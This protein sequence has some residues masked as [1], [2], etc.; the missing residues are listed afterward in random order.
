MDINKKLVEYNSQLHC[1]RLQITG[2]RIFFRAIFPPKPGETEP[3]RTRITSHCNASASGL[4]L[5]YERAKLIDAE[6]V[7]GTF[8]WTP[9][10]RGKLKSYAQVEIVV[11]IVLVRDWVEKFEE[12]YWL[13]NEKTLNKSESFRQNYGQS[14]RK[15]E[16]D[17]PI[18]LDVFVSAVKKTTPDQAMRKRDV[19]AYV[20]L[21]RFAGLN[22]VELEKL[23]SLQGNYSYRQVEPYSLPSDKE[24][25]ELWQSLND[26][27]WTWAFS[28]FAIWGIR[29]HEL[30]RM[31]TSNINNEVPT[32]EILANSKTG[33]RKVYPCWSE[34]WTDFQPQNIIY[35][36]WNLDHL[37]N[38]R[39]GSRISQAFRRL[40]MSTKL[41]S[42]RHAYARRMFLRGFG[43]DF[44]AK[45]MGH[46][47]TI[48]KTVYR[49]WWGEGAYDRMY[50]QVMEKWKD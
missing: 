11:E 47:E 8:D 31:D 36:D 26:P 19:N 18:S 29:P 40:N 46:S 4:K 28:M 45:S 20:S 32:I 44:I 33:R 50:D 49:A 27:A 16:G 42:L 24:I 30:F 48:Q 10:L 41:Y 22:S 7:L 5:A 15:L 35:P 13:K 12:D 39:I 2:G 21:G 1:V 9:Y 17:R 25:Y 34:L 38:S 3:R 43:S 37:P 23:K 14:F 6:L